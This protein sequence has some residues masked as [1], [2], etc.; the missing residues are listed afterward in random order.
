[1][2]VTLRFSNGNHA[3]TLDVDCIEV[4]PEPNTNIEIHNGFFANRL[5]DVTFPRGQGVVIEYAQLI[6]PEAARITVHA[7]NEEAKHEHISDQ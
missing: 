1:M 7:M 3:S 6:G 2:K 5:I 4:I